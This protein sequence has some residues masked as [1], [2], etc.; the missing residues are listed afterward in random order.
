MARGETIAFVSI[1]LSSTVQHGIAYAGNNMHRDE[2]EKAETEVP[3]L[4]LCYMPS[5]YLNYPNER[6]VVSK[7]TSSSSTISKAGGSRLVM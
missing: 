3:Q 4:P 1:I 6:R 2:E 5:P 7:S